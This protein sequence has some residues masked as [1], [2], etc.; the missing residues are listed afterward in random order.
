MT[1]T[2][3]TKV[4]K[5]IKHVVTVKFREEEYELLSR[6]ADQHNLTVSQTIRMAVELQLKRQPDQ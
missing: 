2:G 1:R 5:P 4:D 6:Y 3:R